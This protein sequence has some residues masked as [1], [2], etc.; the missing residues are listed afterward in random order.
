VQRNGLKLA[1]ALHLILPVVNHADAIV[2][3]ALLLHEGSES[4]KIESV[5]R[6][7]KETPQ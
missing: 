1:L 4:V 6:H 3:L 5:S 7:S 2:R